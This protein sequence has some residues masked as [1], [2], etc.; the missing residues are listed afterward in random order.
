MTKFSFSHFSLALSCLRKY[1]YV[2]IEKLQEP[3]NEH[4][5]FGSALHA[6][7]HASL[8]NENAYDVFRMYWESEVPKIAE[9]GRFPPDALL[10]I[11]LGFIE[12][13]EK[14][15]KPKMKVIQL[16]TKLHGN[17]GGI[18]IEGTPDA[19]VEYDGVKTL[20]DFKTTGYNYDKDKAKS[21]LQLRL[22][23]ALL[24]QNGVFVDQ[25]MFLPFVKSTGGIQNPII[26]P[27]DAESNNLLFA[28]FVEYAKMLGDTIEKQKTLMR[29]P[30]S[31]IMG[32][33]K[34]HF[35]DKCWSNK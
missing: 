6:A 3:Q 7:M 16:E 1:Q 30:A 13:F 15:Y 11:G 2:V 10:E 22:Y 34:C 33:S 18:D 12:K 27:V 29:N 31:C 32:K 21:S 28:E 23:T 20:I 25:V 26:E 5:A 4:F 17:I 8:E 35:Y 24:A 9:F 14:R 19:V